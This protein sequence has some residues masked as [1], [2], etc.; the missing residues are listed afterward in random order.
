VDLGE[1]IARQATKVA[2]RPR[3]VNRAAEY[4]MLQAVQA[5]E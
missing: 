3:R 2:S 1:V 4:K 5:G